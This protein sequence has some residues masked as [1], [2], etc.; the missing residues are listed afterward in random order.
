M[1]TALLLLLFA[2]FRPNKEISTDK[3]K[4]VASS[5]PASALIEFDI[6]NH[7]QDISKRFYHCEAIATVNDTVPLRILEAE[8]RYL[9]EEKACGVLH[10]YRSQAGIRYQQSSSYAKQNPEAAADYIGQVNRN[11][12]TVQW[13]QAFLDSR[14]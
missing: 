13:N 12:N 4:P 2:I 10:V 14:K 7:F 3:P 5:P 6:V 1:A 11:D 9:A 8:L